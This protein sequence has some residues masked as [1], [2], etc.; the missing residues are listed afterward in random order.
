MFPPKK[1][2]ILLVVL[3][4]G[5]FLI[6]RFSHL[7]KQ[8]NN[9]NPDN[10]RTNPN[11]P[12]QT[13]Q[14]KGQIFTDIEA[15]D[16][17][18]MSVLLIDSNS[19]KIIYQKS[20]DQQLPIA[21]LTKL[22]TAA[23]ALEMIGKNKSCKVD[24]KELDCGEA[25]IGLVN[26]ERLSV[27][28][29]LYG[30]LLNSGNDAAEVLAGSTTKN[31]RNEY[32]AWMNQKANKLELKNTEYINP[33]GLDEE[34]KTN[35]SSAMDLAKLFYYLTKN[36]PLFK[37]IIV[38]KEFVLSANDLHR[39][40]YLASTAWDFSNNYPYLIGGKSG[41]TD[42]AGFCLLAQAK[43]AN[44]QTLLIILGEPS[45][46]DIRKDSWNLFNYGFEVI[47]KNN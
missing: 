31:G 14:P 44:K 37:E 19:Q 40:Y 15:P 3:T 27:E 13:W 22:G 38:T 11:K 7:N 1:I 41:N 12:N 4:L 32:I 39:N 25:A 30:M 10:D 18:A 9:N 5:F 17:K 46:T 28:E 8:N 29:L 24:T 35:L 36:F 33:T 21:S 42:K 47:D 34:N 2:L 43:K 45:Y 6:S 23:I 16:H 20:P 26:G